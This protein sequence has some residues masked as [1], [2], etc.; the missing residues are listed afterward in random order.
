M[1]GPG[2][3][4]LVYRAW[5]PELG[6]EVV[7][8]IA[9]DVRTDP[10][11]RDVLHE[12]RV[13]A[14][15]RHPNLAAVYGAARRDGRA[16]VWLELVDG[17]TLEAALSHVGR[18]SAREAALIG[19]DVCAA[20]GAMHEAGVLHRDLTTRQ[21][22]RDRGGRIV[23]IPFGAGRDAT[24]TG[25]LS[26]ALPFD[27]PQPA[28]G[29]PEIAEGGRPSVSSDIYR[30]GALLHRLVAG[31]TPLGTPRRSLADVRSDLPLEFIRAVERALATDPADR[32]SSASALQAAL[33][34]LW[35]P[36]MSPSPPKPPWRPPGR[37]IAGASVAALI[38]ALGM[39]IGA[40]LTR[41]PPP[42]EVRF[43]ISPEG[44]R[45]GASR[46]HAGAAA[47][48]TPTAV[49]CALAT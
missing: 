49:D 31:A 14:K 30:V 25:R 16:G 29:W 15:V 37:L 11:G 33:T 6:Q 8:T 4:G 20:L 23:V 18:F 1:I 32:H 48:R 3:R 21:V 19:I 38:V 34:T 45:S 28:G 9:P 5:D 39:G 36:L 13:L 12:A 27:E 41:E 24:T 17:E 22:I 46:F 42:A 26:R 47:W 40:W 44:G 35:T 2:P 10:A 7:L 43:D